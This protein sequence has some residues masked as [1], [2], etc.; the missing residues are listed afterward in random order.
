M[1]HYFVSKHQRVI[2][3]R[4]HDNFNNSPVNPF[5]HMTTRV[6][7]FLSRDFSAHSNTTLS[8]L[9]WVISHVLY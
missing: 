5:I 3:Q 6:R 8:M 9:S 1:E 4:T 2:G 7:F